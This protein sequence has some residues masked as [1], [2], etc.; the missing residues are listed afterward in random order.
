MKG[1]TAWSVGAVITTARGKRLT[2]LEVI[3]LRFG[4]AASPEL[5]TQLTQVTNLEQ[6]KALHRQAVVASTLE[7]FEHCVET[8]LRSMPDAT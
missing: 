1:E 8:T 5:P 4:E 7:E 6:L 2:I 3:S